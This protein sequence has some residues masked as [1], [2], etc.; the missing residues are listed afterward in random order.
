MPKLSTFRTLPYT[1]K[2]YNYRD[3][4]GTGEVGDSKR[5]YFYVRDIKVDLSTGM[6]GRITI[7]FGDDALNVMPAARLEQLKDK[8]GREIYP[9]GIW[10]LNGIMP[11]V[12]VF[13]T[14]EGFQAEAR[15]THETTVV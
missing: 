6:F 8:N 13:G 11:I 12:T 2:L 1:A 3:V 15:L 7:Y 14:T 9:G 10:T 4:T 5:T